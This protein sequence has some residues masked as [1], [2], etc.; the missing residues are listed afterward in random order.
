MGPHD[1]NV[2]AATRM[3][4]FTVR[5]PRISISYLTTQPQML[6]YRIE[7]K[8]YPRSWTTRGKC[9]DISFADTERIA[10]YTASQIENEKLLNP[11]N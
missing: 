7:C 9:A 1:L 2:I 10:P 4:I 3:H 8:F 11:E 5:C 6:K